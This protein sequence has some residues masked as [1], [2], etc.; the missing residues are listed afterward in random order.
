MASED[1]TSKIVKNASAAAEGAREK[2]AATTGEAK[3]AVGEVRDN[4]KDALDQSIE[5]R[6]Y[7]TLLF[8]LGLGFVMGA[9]WRR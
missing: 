7:T 9:I 2:F 3:D 6:P 4:L 8:A 5:E 1:L